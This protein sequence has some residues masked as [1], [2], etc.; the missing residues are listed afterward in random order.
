LDLLAEVLVTP[1]RYDP[2]HG[3]LVWHAQL[4]I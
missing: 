1:S 3:Y 4:Y 2:D